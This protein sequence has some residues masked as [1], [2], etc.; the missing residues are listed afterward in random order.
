MGIKW[1]VFR[2][3][4]FYYLH[5]TLG[6][7]DYNLKWC[8]GYSDNFDNFFDDA[9]WSSIISD[10]EYSVSEELSYWGD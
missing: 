5:N 10:A 7:Y 3:A 8:W 4:V 1:F 9:G 2:V 6:R